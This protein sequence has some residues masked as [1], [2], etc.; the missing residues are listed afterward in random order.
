MPDTP[1]TLLVIFRM[2]T[3]E[4]LNIVNE[5]KNLQYLQ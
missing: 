4:H 2:S 1:R 5:P 3:L